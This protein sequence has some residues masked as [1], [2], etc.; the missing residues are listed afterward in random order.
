[1]ELDPAA[2]NWM[3]APE[4]GCWPPCTLPPK[5]ETA[6]LLLELPHAV[7]ARRHRLINIG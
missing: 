4:I 3:D 1:M 7:M 5:P 2:K 6:L